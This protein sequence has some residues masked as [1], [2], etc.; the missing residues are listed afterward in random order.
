[1]DEN[2]AAFAA[3]THFSQL[4]ARV[5]KGESI[6]ITRHGSPVARLV[7]VQ[8]RKDRERRRDTV[9]RLLEFSRH[10]TLGGIDWK[11]LRDEGLM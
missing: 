9:A 5:A 7:P 10:Q 6:T 8:D 3:K 2:V 4:L 1:M 11:E